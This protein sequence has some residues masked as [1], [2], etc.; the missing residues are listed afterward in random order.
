MDSTYGT[1][2][3]A[4]FPQDLATDPDMDGVVIRYEALGDMGTAGSGSFTNNDLGRTST[5]EV[6]HW[7]NLY[8]I[9]GDDICGD[10][11]IADTPTA[12]EAN[13]GCPGFPYN[14][15]DSCGT[16]AN[17]E[18]FMNYMDY[19]DD[20]CMNMFTFGQSD[21]MYAALNIE[22][23]GLLTSLGCGTPNSI[24]ENSFE[25][26]VSISP[27]PNTGVFVINFSNPNSK[28]I[29]INV[30]NLIGET[31]KTINTISGRRE[32]INLSELGNGVYYL[33]ICSENNT[34]VKKVIVTH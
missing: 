9:W 13:F 25:T 19:V 21:R 28:N 24:V 32:Q 6:G 31:I 33:Q 1:L 16:D 22:R 12:Y 3:Y 11:L 7:L 14:A 5:H 2:G 27:N 26:S 8:H 29:N 10:D 34:V 30:I 4:V 17:G 18:M 23:V 15:L 20:Y